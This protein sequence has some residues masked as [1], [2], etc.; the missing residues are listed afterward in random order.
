MSLSWAFQYYRLFI[1]W[2]NEKI[3]K[4]F[5]GE[6][7][8][9]FEFKRIQPFDRAYADNPGPMVLFSTPG[10]F[11]PFLHGHRSNSSQPHR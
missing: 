1:N 10:A 4:T 8:N 5:V 3:K 7:E 2:T 11:L 9:V 6:D